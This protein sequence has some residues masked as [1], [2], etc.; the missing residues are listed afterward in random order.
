MIFF[1]GE[2]EKQRH[3]LGG[4]EKNISSREGIEKCMH[5]C[6]NNGND[7]ELSREGKQS[8]R[9]DS[10]GERQENLTYKKKMKKIKDVTV[11]DK[12]PEVKTRERSLKIKFISLAR[13]PRWKT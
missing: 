7:E 13:G 11:P 2:A 8:E 9:E 3:C 12:K 5:C 4:N 1:V 10:E 6:K